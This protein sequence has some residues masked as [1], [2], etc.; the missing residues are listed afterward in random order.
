MIFHSLSMHVDTFCHSS[1]EKL[2]FSQCKLVAFTISLC[3]LFLKTLNSKTVYSARI[4]LPQ[5]F[6]CLV[7]RLVLEE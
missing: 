1:N 4:I 2:K 5:E 3:Y 6:G 7:N